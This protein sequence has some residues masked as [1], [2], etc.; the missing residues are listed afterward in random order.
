MSD[1][2]VQAKIAPP[3]AFEEQMGIIHRSKRTPETP[4]PNNTKKQ[5]LFLRNLEGTHAVSA[6]T[7]YPPVRS[8][9]SRIAS[10]V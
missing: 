5:S 2:L 3:D 1:S 4:I 6:M 10:S 9:Q 7:M 8:G